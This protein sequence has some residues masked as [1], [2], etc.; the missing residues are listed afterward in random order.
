MV[1][2]RHVRDGR[3]DHVDWLLAREDPPAGRLR[4]FRCRVSPIRITEGAIG[5]RVMADHRPVYLEYQGP[6]SGD[7]GRVERI[8]TGRHRL[9]SGDPDG[10]GTLAMRWND[11]EAAAGGVVLVRIDAV[12]P[13]GV[14]IAPPPPA[15]HPDEPVLWLHPEPPA[16]EAT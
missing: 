13:A 15:E 2:L 16:A 10:P 4:S 5:L 6:I 12:P 3:E 11:G 8:A 9:V 14:V 7:R 1:A